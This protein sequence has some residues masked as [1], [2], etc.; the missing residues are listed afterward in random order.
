MSLAKVM[1]IGNLG[2]DPET[3]F[4]PNGAMNVQFSMAVSRRW[5]DSAGQ[6][7]ERTTWFQVTAW[8]RLAETVNN[9][10]QS[11]YLAKG[12]QVFILGGLESREYVDRQGQTRTSLDVR[13]DELQLLGS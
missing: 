13:A 9:L 12:Q 4:T 8:G 5:N 2:R 1:L 11:G 3:R 6:L 7:Q 10:A